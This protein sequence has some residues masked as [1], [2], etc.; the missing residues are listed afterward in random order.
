MH[1]CM[2]SY[3]H[4]VA[5]SVI[6]FLLIL[7]LTGTVDP[8]VPSMIASH[9]LLSAF[10]CTVGICV[11]I[12]LCRCYIF[13][14]TQQTISGPLEPVYTEIALSANE[15]YERVNPWNLHKQRIKVPHT[16]IINITVYT[17]VICYT[18]GNKN[19]SNDVTV[20]T[21]MCMYSCC[22]SLHIVDTVF[23]API[24]P[25]IILGSLQVMDIANNHL[26]FPPSYLEL[27]FSVHSTLLR[28]NCIVTTRKEILCS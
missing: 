19:S 2:H 8:L 4:Y 5:T 22:N 1:A 6:L 14:R 21:G 26:R 18:L 10:S 9:L 12:L 25:M 20:T 27:I 3:D 23:K 17:Y 28:Y 16:H 11:G 24:N 13:K 15:A 7:S